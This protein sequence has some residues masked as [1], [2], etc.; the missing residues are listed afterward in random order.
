RANQCPPPL[1]CG[2]CLVAI[3]LQ[4]IR[5]V[6][7]FPVDQRFEVQMATG[8]VA[9]GPRV[10][11]N[12]TLRHLLSRTHDIPGHMVVLR[13]EQTA[14]DR[15]VINHYTASRCRYC[16]VSVDNFSR[17]SRL[18]WEATAATVVNT[19][20]NVPSAATI[21]IGAS[22]GWTPSKTRSLVTINRYDESPRTTGV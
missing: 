21:V 16:P 6:T 7:R 17:A 10:T 15:A 4:I 18:N 5:W 14:I 19:S 1:T 20:V 9:C 22:G 3:V 11:N 2:H 13:R 12:L 8:G